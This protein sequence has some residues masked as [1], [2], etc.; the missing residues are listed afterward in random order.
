MQNSIMPPTIP[1]FRDFAE[2]YLPSFQT[3]HVYLFDLRQGVFKNSA[4]WSM[5]W[6]VTL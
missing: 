3:N 2:L 5:S 1:E 4:G 6:R